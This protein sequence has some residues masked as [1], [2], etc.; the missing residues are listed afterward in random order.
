M[1]VPPKVVPATLLDKLL[2]LQEKMNV[3]LEQLLTN[4]G[5]RDLHCKGL[6][7]N[8]ELAAHLN[9]AQATNAIKQA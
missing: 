1:H 2:L 3:A 5:T 7:L 6:D 9:D 8:V 4:R